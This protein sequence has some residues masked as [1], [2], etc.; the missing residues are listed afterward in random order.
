MKKAFDELVCRS[1]FSQLTDSLIVLALNEHEH[2]HVAGRV[3][4]RSQ[5]FLRAG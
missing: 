4:M 3:L 2:E 5:R 1:V